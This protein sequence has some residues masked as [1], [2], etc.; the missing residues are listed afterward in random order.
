[1]CVYIGMNVINILAS[2]VFMS[3]LCVICMNVL[4]RTQDLQ[5]L[6][7]VLAKQLAD[8]PAGPICVWTQWQNKETNMQKL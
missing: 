4:R 2:N 1:M 5:H 3:S 7:C 6:Q 8:N